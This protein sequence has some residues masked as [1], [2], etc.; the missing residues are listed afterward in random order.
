MLLEWCWGAPQH[1]K[2]Q[3]PYIVLAF[4]EQSESAQA[5]FY[6]GWMCPVKSVIVILE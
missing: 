3:L 1:P 6:S 2:Q 5:V 4:C